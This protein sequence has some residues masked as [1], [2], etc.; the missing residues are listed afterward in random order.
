MLNKLLEA[1]KKPEL[2]A[3]ST[4][5]FWDEEHIS[6]GLLEAHLEE[7]HDAASRKPEFIDKSVDWITKVAPPE[8]YNKLLDLGCGPGLYSERLYKRGYRV[9]GIDFS[10]RSIEYGKEMAKKEDHAIDYHHMNYLDLD[11]ENE[12]DV[13][14][15]IYCDYAVLSPKDRKKLLTKIFRAL[16]KGGKFIF[17]VFTPMNYRNGDVETKSWELNEGGFWRPDKHLIL[18]SHFIYPG[19]TRCNQYIIIGHEGNYEI[20]RVWDQPFTPET[21]MDEF[22]GISYGDIS[23]YSDVAGTPYSKES[24]TLTI[25]VQK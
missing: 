1:I 5:K 17:D 13:I 21:I 10:K 15:L 9:T 4:M 18:E 22:T 11:F 8:K 24:Q 3:P 6:K 14:T 16:K 12:F 2:F 23:I 20:V 25:V 7:D 19:N